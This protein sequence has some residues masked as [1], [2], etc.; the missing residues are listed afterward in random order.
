[1]PGTLRAV[2]EMGYT[3]V[4]FAGLFG[5]A[6]ADVRAMLDEI[7]LT[8]ISAHVPFVEMMADPR[9]VFSDYK[10]IGCEYVA[11]PY[12]GEANRPGSPEFE[13]TLENIRFLGKIAGEHGITLLYHNHDFEFIKLDGVYGLDVMYST[14][15]ADLLQTQLDTCWV[16]VGGED[17]AAF[18]RKYSGRAPVVHLKDFYGERSEDMYELIGME[19]KA[20]ARPAG[21]EFRPIGYGMQDFPAILS[22]AE[23][24]GARWVVVEQDN[25]SMGKNPLECAAMSRAELKKLGW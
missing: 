4:E 2:K 6:P 14:V 15:S 10:T 5:Y 16:N 21:F 22:A 13:A 3:G 23:D 18:I 7:G 25:P 20:P 19:K 1:M 24:A 8:A 11:I 12:L 9:K 17:P